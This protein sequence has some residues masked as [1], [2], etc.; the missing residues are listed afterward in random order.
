M[1]AACDAVG[2]RA[3]SETAGPTWMKDF[4]T[5]MGATFSSCFIGVLKLSFSMH[6]DAETLPANKNRDLRRLSVRAVRK[7][8]SM[9]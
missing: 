1:M 2:A 4:R 5:F 7:R 6:L 3:A 8:G 9:S